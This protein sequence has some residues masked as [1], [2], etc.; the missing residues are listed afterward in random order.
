MW[1][2]NTG[3]CLIEVTAWAGLTVYAILVFGSEYI[4]YLSRLRKELIDEILSQINSI[5]TINRPI[6]YSSCNQRCFRNNWNPFNGFNS[7]IPREAYILAHLYTRGVNLLHWIK[8]HLQI[9]PERKWNNFDSN[10][11]ILIKLKNQFDTWHFRPWN[12]YL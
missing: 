12:I 5:F 10:K 4:V 6:F 1:P 8:F 11:Y 2:L 3:G 7:I 9:V